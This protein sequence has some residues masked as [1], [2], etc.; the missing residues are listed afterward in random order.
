[1]SERAEEV[2]RA[3][4][5]LFRDESSKI[6]RIA[7]RLVGGNNALARDV[8]QDACVRCLERA[9]QLRELD[10]LSGWFYR[11]LVN[12]AHTRH[13]RHYALAKAKAIFS[14]QPP[15]PTL[16]TDLPDHG[17]QRRIRDALWDLRRSQREAFV[18]VRLERLSVGE[19]AAI[20]NISEQ[21]LRN[22]LHR[23]EQALK[24]ALKDL[25]GQHHGGRDDTS[26]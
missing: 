21:A 22:H 13:Q 5:D 4:A 26:D 1:M 20:M 18:L 11:T 14:N 25:R 19:S 3:L 9:G 24:V 2:R 6:T 16:P 23:G 17:L 10:A 7:W 12:C 15:M 8:I